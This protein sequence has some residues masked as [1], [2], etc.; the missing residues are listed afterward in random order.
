MSLLFSTETNSC[1]LNKTK[2]VKQKKREK[3]KQSQTYLQCT[4]HEVIVSHIVTVINIR[5][6]LNIQQNNA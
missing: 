5:I 4:R 2:T 6:N 3:V 1:S